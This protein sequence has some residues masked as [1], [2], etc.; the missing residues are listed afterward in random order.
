MPACFIRVNLTHEML[1]LMH[2]P[3][4]RQVVGTQLYAGTVNNGCQVIDK[5]YTF[6][7]LAPRNRNTAHYC[8]HC[9]C[10]CY[11]KQMPKRRFTIAY[12]PVLIAFIDL[13]SNLQRR[14]PKHHLPQHRDEQP[15]QPQHCQADIL[16]TGQ[17]FPAG[18]CVLN[19]GRYGQR[20]CIIKDFLNPPGTQVHKE[21]TADLDVTAIKFQRPACFGGRQQAVEGHQKRDAV[22]LGNEPAEEL[23]V[24]WVSQIEPERLI[25][26]RPGGEL[27][28]RLHGITR[29]PDHK[30][31]QREA[32]I[33]PGFNGYHPLHRLAQ[34][35]QLAILEY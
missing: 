18:R 7:H 27:P 29:Y 14:D 10:F 20:L 12:L 22:L 33:I 17:P 34:Y 25:E 11:R 15:C 8:A 6:K 30:V 3:V 28:Y 13:A 19:P 4:R 23:A 5:G 24:V 21:G 32:L 16:V 2:S 9:Q 26:R 35:V 1:T 31:E